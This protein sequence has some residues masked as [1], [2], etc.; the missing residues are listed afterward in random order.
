[1]VFDSMENFSNYLC[2]HPHF[3]NVYDFIKG[4]NMPD[5]AEGRHKVNS[6]GA[7]ALVKEYVT[8]DISETFVEC[9][10]KF[11]DIQILLKGIERIG[12]C[13][14]AECKEYAYDPDKDLQKLEGELNFI[15]MDL[16]SF[17][18][19]FPSDGHMPELKYGDLKEKVKKIVFKVPILS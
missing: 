3:N 8:K 11:I 18:I 16:K 7:F 14:K 1:M 17:A 13:S 6:H 10:R 12:I 19:F 2:L 9:H 15:K 5:M 4:N